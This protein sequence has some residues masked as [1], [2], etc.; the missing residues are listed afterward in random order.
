[1]KNFF[2][3]DYSRKIGEEIIGSA[4][5]YQTYVLVECPPP[6][7]WEAFGSK[8]V[9][10]NLQLLDRE[11]KSKKLPIRLLLIAKEDSHKNQE[12]TLLI[13]HKPQ[14]L[15]KSYIKREFKL[16]NIDLVEGEIRKW[17]AGKNSNYEIQSKFTRDILICTHGSH[18]Q[19]C[20]RYGNPFYF[21]AQKTIVE[22]QLEEVRIW[23]SS[24][25]G[26][27]RFAPTAIDLPEARYYGLLDQESLQAILCRAGDIK[28]LD[29]VYRGWGLLP[30]ALQ[31]LER[32]I[33]YIQGWDWFNNKV[34]GKVLE[35]SM[36]N[37]TVLAELSYE[38][39][40]GCLYTLQAK[41]IKDTVKTRILKT[42]CHATEESLVVKYA[43]DNLYAKSTEVVS[44]L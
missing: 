9:P 20:A 41:L 4:T 16:P 30:S 10:S 42:S 37:N 29:R 11:L 3:S 32:E 15:T 18:D 28:I 14:G 2:C 25:I 1:M 34:S 8:W 31:V 27:H 39:S 6:W 43:I 13:Y 33:I 44:A 17:L 23:R 36:D 24:H 21:H 35:Q 7:I 40:A 38:N 26:G 5:N 12:T 19:C 22:L